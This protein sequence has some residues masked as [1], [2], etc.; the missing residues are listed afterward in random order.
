MLLN[1]EQI[2][3]SCHLNFGTT[4]AGDAHR[5]LTG[6]KFKCLEPAE[7]GLIPVLNILGTLVWRKS[8]D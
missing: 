4:E 7:V 3:P 1:K 5:N 8:I 2:C 6:E